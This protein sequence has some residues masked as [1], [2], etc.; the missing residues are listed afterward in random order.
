MGV[1]EDLVR[2]SPYLIEHIRRFGDY[3]VHELG[4][5]GRVRRQ[6]GVL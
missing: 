3:S 5:G 2:V 6:A 1:P 4:H